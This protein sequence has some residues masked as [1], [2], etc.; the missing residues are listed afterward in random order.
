MEKICNISDGYIDCFRGQLPIQYIDCYK[1]DEENYQSCFKFY[2]LN[3]FDL[4]KRSGKKRRSNKKKGK[5]L[6]IN[7]TIKQCI[8]LDICSDYESY[9]D[10]IDISKLEFSNI[11]LIDFLHT[12]DVK[13][14][15]DISS[16]SRD[17]RKP[18]D[19]QLER[20]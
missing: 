11:S 16:G 1:M 12:E 8:Y 9:E 20:W 3:L 6:S 2:R 15:Q 5:W 4:R 19:F 17:P 10:N 13:Y 14:I 18:I 7:F